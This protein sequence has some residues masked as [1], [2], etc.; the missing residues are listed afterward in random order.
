M[1]PPLRKLGALL[2]WYHTLKIGLGPQKCP[3]NKSVRLKRHVNAARQHNA[4]KE[5]LGHQQD[6]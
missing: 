2:E 3:S 5:R 6:K 1:L 4:C